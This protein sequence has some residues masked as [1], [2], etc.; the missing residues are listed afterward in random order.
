MKTYFDASVESASSV[1]LSYHG[2]DERTAMAIFLPKVDFDTVVLYVPGGTSG[3]GLEYRNGSVISMQNTGFTWLWLPIWLNRGMAVAVVDFPESLRH[4]TIAPSLRTTKGRIDTL[5]EM[6]KH[7]RDS[8][9]GKKLV[10]YGH[11]Y[12]ALEIGELAKTDLLDKVAIGSGSLVPNL[13]PR[14][15]YINGYVQNFNRDTVKVP[16]LIVHH[17]N[18]KTG[19]YSFEQIRLIMDQFNGIE[20]SG[21]IPHLGN[22]GRDPGPHFFTTQENEVARNIIAWMRDQNYDRYIN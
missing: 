11:S 3:I 14:Y 8:L 5:N 15:P 17:T 21:G 20:V 10:G 19:E 9:P 1:T 4:R 2:Q 12:G 22:P 7:I 16:T 6:I 18:D 13:N